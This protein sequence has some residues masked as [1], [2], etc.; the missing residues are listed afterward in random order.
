MGY[1]NIEIFYFTSSKTGI[2]TKFKNDQAG[3][4]SSSHRNRSRQSL[5]FIGSEYSGKDALLLRD[6]N[7]SCPASRSK[8]TVCG[9]SPTEKPALSSSRQ[10]GIQDRASP[11]TTQTKLSLKIPVT[12]DWPEPS[13]KAIP[14]GF[15]K[16]QQRSPSTIFQA[17][18]PN[19]G[20]TSSAHIQF[21]ETAEIRRNTG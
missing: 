17:S 9:T 19:V 3:Q 15:Q 13:R 16:P 4:G 18:Q 11:P 8:W 6:R 20:L 1:W 14:P 7:F 5:S 2:S 21:R 12:S 10:S